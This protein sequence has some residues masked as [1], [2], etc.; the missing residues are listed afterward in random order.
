MCTASGSFVGIARGHEGR[1]VV[2]FSRAWPALVRQP[3]L[4]LNSF[5]VSI[6]HHRGN[7]HRLPIVA[8]R[9]TRVRVGRRSRMVVAGRLVLGWDG[10]R[11]P[12]VGA[13]G[14]HGPLIWLIGPESELATGPR[15]SIANDVEIVIGPRATV[16]IGAG[17]YI[18]PETRVLCMESIEIGEGCA[19]SWD[20]QIV[21]FDGH[22]LV[23]ES[24]GSNTAAV[25]IGDAV[26]IGAGARILKGVTVGSGAV[27]GAGAVVTHSIAARALVAGNPA[28]V[29]RDDVTWQV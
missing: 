3:I 16:R 18:N 10:T 27:V 22:T 12:G 25:T 29:V 15:V 23:T 4:V 7:W 5:R 19:I 9:T 17:T 2:R 6:L 13:K 20:V 26:W 14:S 1:G 24:P 8:S 28:R 21:D 11:E